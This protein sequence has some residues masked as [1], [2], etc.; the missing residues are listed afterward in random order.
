MKGRALRDRLLDLFFPCAQCMS[1]G[2]MRKVSGGLCESCR[3]KLRPATPGGRPGFGWIEDMRCAYAYD[4]PARDMVRKMKFHGEYD[5]PVRLFSEEMRR[6]YLEAGWK[7][8]AVVCAPSS[9]G[10]LR[11]RGY[12]QAEKL[13]RG[14]AGLLN[15][16]YIPHVLKK[17]RGVRTQV[18][19]NAQQRLQNMKD[20][21]LPGRRAPEVRGKNVLLVDDVL[22]TGAT[23]EACARALREAGAG[24]IYLMTAAKRDP[25]T[26]LDEPIG[27]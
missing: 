2:S 8:E 12:N 10:T 24:E 3:E 5:L 1:C 11:R 9:P 25:Q 23:A 21:I 26:H 7:A 20:A 4:G 19:L 16:R 14:F 17:R 27:D 22:T 18:G 15:L 13:A 6:L